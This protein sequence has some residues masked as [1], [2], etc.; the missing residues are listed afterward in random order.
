MQSNDSPCYRLQIG[1]L[2][3]FRYKKSRAFFCPA[4]LLFFDFRSIFELE[5]HTAVMKNGDVCDYCVPDTII[6]L[7]QH[8]AFQGLDDILNL[9]VSCLCWFIFSFC[10]VKFRLQF[11]KAFILFSVFVCETVGVRSN[12]SSNSVFKVLSSVSSG[13][14]GSCRAAS[15]IFIFLI[16]F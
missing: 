14:K 2:P 10:P 7:C 4:L 8:I 5:Y 11:F 16:I 6:K 3:I 9:F 13:W 12:V 1:F 15:T